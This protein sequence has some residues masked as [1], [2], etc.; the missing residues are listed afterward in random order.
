M[1]TVTDGTG[2]VVLSLVAHDGDTV[3]NGLFLR[4]GTYTIRYTLLA[5]GSVPPV[6]YT[7]WGNNLSD[8][9]G[10]GIEDPTQNPF[11]IPGSDPPL[12]S[13]PGG[14]ISSDPY[15]FG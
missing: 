3:S 1:M 7:L 5:G 14:I 15:L 13:Y 6:A 4:V 9:I 11:Y 2:N 8:P 12:F 10:T